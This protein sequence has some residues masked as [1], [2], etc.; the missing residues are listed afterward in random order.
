MRRA[1]SQPTSAAAA[2]TI[3]NGTPNTARARNAAT[4]SPTSSGWVSARSGDPDHGLGDDGDHRGAEPG[5]QG[6]DRGGVAESDI[7]R[8]QRE[9]DD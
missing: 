5:E 4:A 6:G 7:Q 8:G 2:M 9:Q 1:A 3:G